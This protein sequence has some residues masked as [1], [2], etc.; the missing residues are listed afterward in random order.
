MYTDT[1][2]DKHHML[3]GSTPTSSSQPRAAARCSTDTSW[4]AFI[5]GLAD[6]QAVR[7]SYA[8]SGIFCIGRYCRRYIGCQN[9][10]CCA[11][12]HY[13]EIPSAYTPRLCSNKQRAHF[14]VSFISCYCQCCPA[15]GVS[16]IHACTEAEKELYSLYVAALA[17]VMQCCHV[18]LRCVGCEHFLYGTMVCYIM[19]CIKSGSY[20]THLVEHID[21]DSILRYQKLQDLKHASSGSSVK[22]N[23]HGLRVNTSAHALPLLVLPL[24][25]QGG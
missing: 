3:R 23:T 8:C 24:L 1:C 15:C 16:K 20:C 5:L 17:G 14:C 22:R 9:F 11:L 13:A 7:S 19:F 6:M 18:F 10:T 2:N 4:S 25:L 21:I 12:L